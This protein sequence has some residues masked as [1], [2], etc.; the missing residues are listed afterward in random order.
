MYDSIREGLGEID[1]AGNLTWKAPCE[2]TIGDDSCSHA[3]DEGDH[4]DPF[5]E[6][7]FSDESD[8]D[9][10]GLVKQRTGQTI[11]P[12]EPSVSTGHTSP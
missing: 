9:E 10:N 5:D 7:Y 6:P 8:S 2:S 12:I 11:T 3:G 1:N 4:V